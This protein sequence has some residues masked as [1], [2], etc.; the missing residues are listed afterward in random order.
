MAPGHHMQCIG[1]S[2]EQIAAMDEYPE[3]YMLTDEEEIEREARLEAATDIKAQLQWEKKWAIAKY[4]HIREQWNNGG[5]NPP[6]ERTEEEIARKEYCVAF[7][8][9]I[10]KMQD[11]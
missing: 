3:K 7:L 11:M 1:L 6:L 8:D 2:T 5:P 9:M 4:R 10:R